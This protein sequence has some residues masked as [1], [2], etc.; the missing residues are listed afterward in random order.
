MTSLR[1]VPDLVAETEHPTRTQNRSKDFHPIG[2]ISLPHDPDPNQ[3]EIISHWGASIVVGRSGTGKTTALIYK[4]HG[5]ENSATT[6]IRQLFV[7]RSRVLARHVESSFSRLTD[8]L[9][10]ELT[11]T[12]EPGKK[13]TDLDQAVVEFDNEI[14]L[15]TDLPPRFSELEDSHFPLFIS[16]DKLCSL[17][18]GDMEKDREK[19]DR[20]VW[21]PKPT[22]ERPKVGYEEFKTIYWPQFREC[23]RLELNPFLAYAEIL[24][25]IKGYAGA[26]E[27]PEGYLTRE[28]YI[29]DDLN[30]V[31]THLDISAKQK[32]YTMFER[33]RELKA[34]RLELDPA[35]GSHYILRA[36]SEAKKEKDEKMKKD[37]ESEESN[38][39]VEDVHLGLFQNENRRPSSILDSALEDAKKTTEEQPGLWRCLQFIDILYVDEVQ[40]NLMTDIRLLTYLSS[41]MSNTYWG[42]DT[43]Q[44][45]L[46]GSGFRIRDLGPYLYNQVCDESNP[47][48]R[49]SSRFTPRQFELLV[50]YRS[51]DG[52]VQCAASIVDSLYALF[53]E[54]LDR[55]ARESGDK[56]SPE[57]PV[58]LTDI[59]SDTAAFVGFLMKSNSTIGAQQA[60]LVRSEKLEKELSS[61]MDG[62]CP[63]LTITNCK[64]LEFDDIILYNFFAESECPTAWE[65]VHG[66][67]TKQHRTGKDSFPPLSL[68]NELK[69]LYVAIT[70]ARKRCWFWDQ[71]KLMDSMRLWWESQNL[72]N[73]LSVTSMIEWGRESDHSQWILKGRE[74]FSNGM[75][76]LAAGCFRRGGPDA[77]NNYRISTAYYQM[78]RAK[79]ELLRRNND[80]TRKDLCMAADELKNCTQLVSA[81]HA[82]PL[83]FHAAVCLEL[84]RQIVKS[85]EAF[86]NAG[87]HERAVRSLLNSEFIGHCVR[88]L[89]KYGHILEQDVLEESLNYCRKHYLETWPP[90]KNWKEFESRQIS[91]LLP[92][93]DGSID[94]MLAF[95]RKQKY[96]GQLKVLL[97]FYQRFDELAQM[98][99]EDGAPHKALGFY[100]RAFECY[101]T[102][103]SLKNAAA[104]VVAS[105]EWIFTLGSNPSRSAVKDVSM[106]IEEVLRYSSHIGSPS[107]KLL[108][109]FLMVIEK[110]GSYS[111][112]M[113]KDWD[114]A[115]PEQ[116]LTKALILYNTLLDMTW[117]NSR[118]LQTVIPRLATWKILNTIVS[119]L[120]EAAEPSKMIAARRLFGFKPIS[121]DIFVTPNYIVAEGSLLAQSSYQYPFK[122]QRNSN[123]E[124]LIPASWV[125]RIIKEKL[126]GSLNDRLRGIHFGLVRSSLISLSGF[127]PHTLSVCHERNTRAITSDKEFEGRLN[128]LNQAIESFSPLCA[129]PFDATSTRDRP[130]LVELWVDHLFG[131]IY[132]MSGMIEEF[133]SIRTRPGQ[134]SYPGVRAC[135]KQYLVESSSTD[136]WKFV[137]AYSLVMQLDTSKLDSNKTLHSSIPFSSDR[138]SEKLMINL[139]FNWQE[140]RGLVVVTH[141]LREIL[142][143][144][145]QSLDVMVLIHLIELITCDSIFHLR[146]PHSA[147]KD[148]FSGLVL[149]FSWARSLS[150]RYGK[151]QPMRDTDSLDILLEIMTWVSDSLGSPDVGRWST[152]A[153][154]LSKKLDSREVFLLR[155]CWCA[156]LL[157]S[158]TPL[159]YQD[160]AV[161]SLIHMARDPYEQMSQPVYHRFSAVVD[162]ESCTRVL[163]ETFGHETLV[164]L[165]HY[166]SSSQLWEGQPGILKV[167]FTQ[168]EDVSRALQKCL[169]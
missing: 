140:P 121:S 61:S 166:G 83:W 34:A 162:R 145:E 23:D 93:F 78:S 49:L 124:L 107:Q 142:F 47:N 51:H 92:L 114:Q 70:R 97:E 43:A 32:I 146:A 45:I 113:V 30:R 38:C 137:V 18:E 74:Y 26:M 66:C 17:I 8:S 48:Q 36:L 119:K 21:T 99:S 161:Y 132:P 54:S 15:R 135:I 29:S 168:P 56:K 163:C 27:R 151:T 117:A 65:F 6:H 123:G 37:V 116:S 85:A 129:V 125:D 111:P 169:G 157:N 4:M 11:E 67:F 12:T 42:G 115:D 164:G 158:P 64:G 69:L 106:L 2:R 16:F 57:L 122:T 60:I 120:A 71:S 94:D 153:D 126:R 7:T 81:E 152:R 86:I 84:A 19:D 159:G 128:I 76:K 138:L 90:Y 100:I 155:L 22:W 33:Y 103:S 58:V 167:A 156:A 62:F 13:P 134:P 75:Y 39:D 68:C 102:P 144:T 154:P 105:A 101:G 9:S 80:Q 87:L 77:E 108:R 3:Y 118:E 52:I 130:G 131:V 5:V 104:L 96:W 24:G 133:T 91:S 141:G 46:A 88:L 55:L 40:D 73:V 109:F 147:T 31:S 53:P 50:N 44:T 127:K 72:V 20:H 35:D 143:E 10:Q 110:N 148:G 63:I 98:F 160:V 59:G 139:F 1:I 149:P 28:Q 25:V 95:A 79:L 112:D 14:D 82:R 41:N 89:L 136:I 150:K 165:S